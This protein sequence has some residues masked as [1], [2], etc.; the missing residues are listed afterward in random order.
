MIDWWGPVIEEY[1][2]ASEINGLTRITSAETLV[3]PGSVGRPH[4]GILHICDEDGHECPVG[5]PGMIYFER[6]TVVFTYHNDPQKTRSSQ[7]PAHETWSAVGDIGY[8]DEDNYLYLTDRKAFMIISG[9]VNI[10]PQAIENAIVL[11]PKVVD[12]AVF[13][14]PNEELGEEVK[15]VIEPLPEVAP[16][17]ALATEIMDFISDKIA[18]YMLP[19][20]IDFTDALPRLPTGKLYKTKLR[21]QYWPS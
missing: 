12:V 10:Y 2:G 6:D 16:S 15:A 7:H 14:V 5:T 19:R 13:G 11:H 20:S 17:P 8:V 4:L 18:R 3:K 1:Y 9:G 21:A